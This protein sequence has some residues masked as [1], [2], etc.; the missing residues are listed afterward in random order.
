MTNNFLRY[1]TIFYGILS[2]RGEPK[3]GLWKWTVPGAS[4]SFWWCELGGQYSGN[5]GLADGTN[6]QGYVCGA[7]Q[8]D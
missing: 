8:F 4:S 2:L 6:Q 5:N 1:W 7:C 3:H